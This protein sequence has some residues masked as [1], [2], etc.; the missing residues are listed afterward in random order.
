[1]YNWTLNGWVIASWGRVRRQSH[2]TI[3]MLMTFRTNAVCF[4]VQVHGFVG[5]T[6]LA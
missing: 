3:I 2:E 6:L 1:M 5:S 4:R